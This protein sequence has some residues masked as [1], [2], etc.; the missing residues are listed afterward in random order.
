[1]AFLSVAFFDYLRDTPAS[2]RPPKSARPSGIGEGTRKSTALNL[3]LLHELH[4]L[5]SMMNRRPQFREASATAGFLQNEDSCG[6]VESYCL[7]S[8]SH[9][10]VLGNPGCLGAW[11]PE[12]KGSAMRGQLLLL[13]P[14]LG[15]N[16]VQLHLQSF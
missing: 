2:S 15:Q 12:G 13:P 8:C 5:Q 11:V 6:T 10:T 1:M 3:R 14:R 16:D 7:Q 9:P 4:E